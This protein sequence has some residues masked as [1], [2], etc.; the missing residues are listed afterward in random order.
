MPPRWSRDRLGSSETAF[1]T[2]LARLR[3]GAPGSSAGRSGIAQACHRGGEVCARGHDY[4]LAG[5]LLPTRRAPRLDPW[6]GGR[7]SASFLSVW[8][9]AFR[10]RA[11]HTDGLVEPAHLSY[12]TG[13]AVEPAAIS[14]RWGFPA[15]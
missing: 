14:K 11:A 1:H 6:R 7:G 8:C 13:A 3:P 2:R 12:R 15:D 9:V 5:A 4:E 10:F